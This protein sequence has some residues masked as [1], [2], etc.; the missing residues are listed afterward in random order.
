MRATNNDNG[1]TRIPSIWFG[2]FSLSSV[3]SVFCLF[4][5][6]RIF[7][8]SFNCKNDL[9]RKRRTAQEE[10]DRKN[11]ALQ[12]PGKP[13]SG[14]ED[15]DDYYEIDR[16][17]SRELFFFFVLFFLRQRRRRRQRRTPSSLQW[18]EDV[19]VS[20]SLYLD[21]PFLLSLFDTLVLSLY[22][23]RRLPSF[24][25]QLNLRQN[26]SQGFYLHITI[27]PFFP[28]L[29][30]PR[31]LIQFLHVV[32][33]LISFVCLRHHIAYMERD[34]AWQG[35]HGL[36]NF[37]IP[38]MVTWV[39]YCMSL[40]LPFRVWLLLDAQDVQDS[41][42]SFLFFSNQITKSTDVMFS[43]TKHTPILTRNE[44]DLNRSRESS[45]IRNLWWIQ[46][47]LKSWNSAGDAQSGR[48]CKTQ[49]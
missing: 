42:M 28:C 23:I 17:G 9:K 8:F 39:T 40:S 31:L 21:H 18:R 27:S 6:T 13:S 43:D 48:N 5:S 44:L 35:E 11:E 3:L 36:T 37:P 7:F 19:S 33:Q 16:T 14:K 30:L 2:R 10:D 12:R 49:G 1:C 34:K 15:D 41:W 26:V 46:G 47:K 22:L 4:S 38:W 32:I 45:F 29:S 24:E 25:S 20:L